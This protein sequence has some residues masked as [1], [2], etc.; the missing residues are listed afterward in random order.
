MRGSNDQPW[1]GPK[2]DAAIWTLV[3]RQHGAI[4][5]RQLL[6]LGLSPRQIERRIATG[7]LH[8]TW[9]GVYAVGRPLL[10]RRGR[11]MAAVLACGPDAVLSHG[12]AAALWGFGN[13]QGGT[14]DISVPAGRRSRQRGIR[15]YRRTEAILGD[16]LS[17]D[18][19]PLTSLVRTLIDQATRLRPMQ[20]ERAVN[21]ADKLD[22]VRADALLAYLDDY[23]GQP[24]A[25]PLRKL[26]DPLAFRLSDSELEQRMR[27]LALEAGLPVPE[28]KAWVNGYEVDFYWADLGIVVEADGL[29]YHR[30]ASQQRRGLERD[31]THLAAGM[32]P[33]RFSHWQIKHDAAHVRKI[34]RHT[35]ARAQ[36]DG[37]RLG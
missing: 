24:G 32:W 21:E 6:K 1:N 20:L 2:R 28:T 7:R 22:L 26:L 27:P 5:R 35:L 31:Q 15:V 34:L 8:P 33:L 3:R 16:A 12:S 9:R 4:S 11:W 29:R 10:G 14:I 37:R 36:A 25:A 23:R 13:E 17:R 19:I 18:G 30:T